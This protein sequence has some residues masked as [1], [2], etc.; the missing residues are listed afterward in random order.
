MKVEGNPDPVPRRFLNI[1][2]PPN[3]SI[4]SAACFDLIKMIAESFKFSRYSVLIE[5]WVLVLDSKE[6]VP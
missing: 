6:D 5:W 2:L 3:I 1:I 4:S